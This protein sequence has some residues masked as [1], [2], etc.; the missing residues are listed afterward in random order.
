MNQEFSGRNALIIGGSSGIGRA[1][2]HQLADRGAQVLVVGRSEEKLAA[3]KLGR[4][5]AV[6]VLGADI[7]EPGGLKTVL[8]AIGNATTPFDLLVNAAGIFAPKPYLEHTEAEYDAY[9]GIS[10]ALFFATQAAVRRMVPIN[11][12]AIVSIGSMW[13]QQ[14]ILATPSAAYSMAK[15]GVH[16]MT[17]HL[18]ME[19]GKHRI[20]VNAVSPAIV[21][22]PVFE[23][24][25]PKDQIAAVL[26][27]FNGFHPIGRIG[28]VQDVA[29]VVTFLLSDQADWVT[30]A[31]W[32]VDGGVMA[33][34]NN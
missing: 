5:K 32:D 26:G 17:Q 25:I 18:A 24:F 4:E 1:V 14:A 30:G 21:D 28:T 13:A 3:T 12:G 11:R 7:T 33:G 34:R 23:S 29:S 22:T 9:L 20:R 15:A 6:R 8:E 2:A 27:S 31:L 10:R 16:A 19:L